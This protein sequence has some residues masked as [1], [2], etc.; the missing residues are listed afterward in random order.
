MCNAFNYYIIDP[1]TFLNEKGTKWKFHFRLEYTKSNR[2]RT[3]IKIGWT[4]QIL[5]LRKRKIYIWDTQGLTCH[6]DE[7]RNSEVKCYLGCMQQ[8]S[9]DQIKF[10]FI[11]DKYVTNG[12]KH[13]RV[14]KLLQQDISIGKTRPFNYHVDS[15]LNAWKIK[16][17]LKLLFRGSST[18]RK[19]R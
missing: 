12:L 6:C 15:S 19:W 7:S 13:L 3:K 18:G 1:W 4:D 10:L 11:A 14:R 8:S 17:E 2:I 9:P 5:L 16:H